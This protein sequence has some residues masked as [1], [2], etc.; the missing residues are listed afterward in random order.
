MLK[1]ICES[2]ESEIDLLN[3]VNVA[4]NFASVKVFPG[5]A[6]VVH[7]GYQKEK[8][9][10]IKDA[11]AKALLPSVIPTQI[12]D[13]C[14]I[15]QQLKEK[16]HSNIDRSQQMTI[17]TILPKSWSVQKVQEEFG[18]SNYMVRKAKELV[19]NQGILPNPNPK[20]GCCL[21]LITVNLVK[22]FYELDDVSRIMPG[23]KDFVSVRQGDKR[24]HV[25]KRLLLSNLKELY[26][27][28]KAKYPTEKI[29]FS[30]FAELP[31]QHCVLA[32]ASGTHAVC[33]CTIHQNVKLMMI[34]G[35]IAEQ[36]A[37]D[38]IP[39][40]EYDHCLARIICN[41]PQLDCFFRI[42]S[43]CPGISDLK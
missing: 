1:S 34:C 27:Q 20:H 41:P 21:P 15:I 9:S 4:I 7:A 43:S 38:E 12:D 22:D 14:E 37:E 33:V 19:K 23:K 24:V 5:Y 8:L 36:S 11:A 16:F 39:L 6:T 40:K 10:K 28:F 3:L 30:K 18:V 29:G 17:L 32:G 42:C 13:G 31:P 2:V 35:K 25:Q 26:Q